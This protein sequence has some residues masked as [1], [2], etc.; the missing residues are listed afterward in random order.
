MNRALRS[1]LSRSMRKTLRERLTAE[2][3]E[4]V[5]QQTWRIDDELAQNL[6]QEPNLGA[7]L[8]VRA[9]ALTASVY[10]ALLTAGL[11]AEEARELTSQ[12]TWPIYEK[13][14]KPRWKL[15]RLFAKHPLKRVKLTMGW[16]MRFPYSA[17][18]YDMRFVEA[19]EDV[20]AFDVH[21]CPAASYFAA[22]GLSELCVSSW[23]NLDYPLAEQWG[24]VLDRSQTLAGGASYCN[25]RFRPH[26]SQSAGR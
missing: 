17:P 5:I 9:A 15:S 10:R 16:S 11:E 25:F 2:E 19:G 18:G 14:G 1:I 20:I 3:L 4:Q 26:E 13:I 8:V 24:V 23:C 12:V 21:R 22:Q 7:R 6:P